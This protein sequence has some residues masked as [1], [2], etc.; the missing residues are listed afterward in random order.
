MV[1]DPDRAREVGQEDEA[2]FQRGNEERLRVSVVRRDL[3]AELGDPR[4]QLLGGQVDVADP[5][6]GGQRA[7]S[8]LYRSASRS[9][10]R[11]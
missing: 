1:V 5:Q 4:R 6:V 2:G 11:L 10:S 8:S 7:S 3:G 9:T